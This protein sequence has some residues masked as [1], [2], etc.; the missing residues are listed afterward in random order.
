MNACIVYLVDTY[1]IEYF[2]RSLKCLSESKSLAQYPI[3]AFYESIIKSL[4]PLALGLMSS[5]VLVCVYVDV[6]LPLGVFVRLWWCLWWWLVV[7][8]CV[9]IKS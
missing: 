9:H 5:S 1:D 3:Y 7:I 6:C 8:G 4:T 2:K